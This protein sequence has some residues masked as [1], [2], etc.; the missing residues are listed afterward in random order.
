MT[1]IDVRY[2]DNG[3]LD[4][5]RLLFQKRGYVDDI[6]R[7]EH[8]EFSPDEWITGVLTSRWVEVI[9]LDW[10]R[11]LRS[12]TTELVINKAQI[13]RAGVDI[14]TVWVPVFRADRLPHHRRNR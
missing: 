4:H 8:V 9:T 12:R 7:S 13:R 1:E 14:V 2:G 3:W 6:V 11:A 10:H 5:D